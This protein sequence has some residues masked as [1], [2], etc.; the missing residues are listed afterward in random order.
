MATPDDRTK[1][2]STAET[3]DTRQPPRPAP[4]DETVVWRD[5]SAPGN[6]DPPRAEAPG[7]PADDDA[8]AFARVL[9]EIGLVKS[10]EVSPYLA[11]V[12]QAEP[13]ALARQLIADG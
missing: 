13:E 9:T 2:Y 6:D 1:D 7:A 5:L 4:A 8:V 11:R 10:S 12:G 3:P